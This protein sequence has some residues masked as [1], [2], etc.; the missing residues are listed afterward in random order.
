MPKP[1]SQT[2]PVARNKASL[3]WRRSKMRLRSFGGAFVWHDAL[4]EAAE[5][6][7]LS[8]S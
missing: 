5:G 3:L 1:V 8:D 7:Q 6:K 2:S 4:R